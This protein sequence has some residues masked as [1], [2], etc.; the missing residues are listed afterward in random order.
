MSV[1]F[2]YDTEIM[3]DFDEHVQEYIEKSIAN[4]K[5]SEIKKVWKKMSSTKDHYEII[6][7]CSQISLLSPKNILADIKKAQTYAKLKQNDKAEQIFKNIIKK[8]NA[9]SDI[10]YFFYG[11]FL[12]DIKKY[13]DALVCFDE[14]IKLDVKSPHFW[15]HKGTT[16]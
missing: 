4:E 1:D 10:P 7:L 14:A 9:S 2:E 6:E 16:L 12:E 15:F 11:I 13:S 8:T 3:D 5:N